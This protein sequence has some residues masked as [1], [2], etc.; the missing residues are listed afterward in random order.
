MV[1][2]RVV[3]GA[4]GVP[5]RLRPGPEGVRSGLEVDFRVKLQRYFRGRCRRYGGVFFL[6]PGAPGTYITGPGLPRAGGLAIWPRAPG[7]KKKAV[8]DLPTI[9]FIF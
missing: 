8:L 4:D 6:A 3:D 2:D 9:N 1:V 7:A 5:R